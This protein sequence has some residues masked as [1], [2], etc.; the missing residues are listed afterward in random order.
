MSKPNKVGNPPRWATKFLH[1]YCKDDLVE[2]I[3]GDILEEYNIRLQDAS[4]VRADLFYCMSIF[5]FLR[6]FAIRQFGPSTQNY[7]MMQAN[8][9][10]VAFRNIRKDK[11]NSFISVFG[12][13]LAFTASMLIYRVVNHESNY[14]AF[15]SNSDQI[16]RVLID[17][18]RDNVWRSYS[19][20][21]PPLGPAIKSFYPEVA[22]S[23]RFRDNPTRILATENGEKVFYEEKI[24]Y[25]D[26]SIF[27][28]FT[29][30][31]QKG[32]PKTALQNTTGI[33]L[34]EQM[35]TKYFGKQDP[36]GK[37]LLL[38]NEIPF[39]V[40]GI[41]APIP[42]N[43]H[44]KFDFLLPFDAFKVP[45]GYTVTL[46]DFGWTSFHTYIKLE[47]NSDPDLLVSKLPTFAKTHFNEEQIA[48][49]KYG[50]IPLKDIY[51]SE[52]RDE[53][54]SSGNK[55]YV[56]ILSSIG[57]LLLILAAFNFTN[58]SVAR[59][60]SR[61]KET[62]MR[63]SLGSTK[64]GLIMRYLSEPMIIVISAVLIA[65][66]LTPML[67]VQLN[68]YFNLNVPWENKHWLEIGLLFTGLAIVIGILSG[69]Y[70]AFIMSS[71][72]PATIL[73]GAFQSSNH[74]G[75][76]QKTLVTFQYAI[77]SFLLI[78]SFIISAQINFLQSRDLGFEKD[79]LLLLRMPGEELNAKFSKLRDVF[80]HN[81]RVQNLSVGGGRMDGEN[82]DV[83][84]TA[85]GMAEPKNM[86]IDAV[87]ED[88]YLTIGT[89]MIAGREF[90][91]L[92]PSDSADGVII[93][94][95]AAKYFNWEPEEAL[96]KKV[97]IGGLA[98]G[99]VIGVVENFHNTSLHNSINPLVV[100]YP[101][102]LL[103]DIY[104]RVSPGDI[105]SLISGLQ[106]DWAKVA[107]DVPFDFV[108]M[109]EH[110][111]NLYNKDIQFSRMVNVF[112]LLTILISILGLYGL[113]ALI[114]T[115]RIKEISIRKILGAPFRQLIFTLSKSF[116]L[117]I[118]IANL[119]AW[120][121]AFWTANIWLNDFAYH[122]DIPI[123][124]F[125]LALLITLT[126]S[127]FTLFIQSRKVAILNPAVAL[128]QE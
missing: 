10:K 51:F 12:L 14:D 74:G 58:I 42:D 23:M 52:I 19:S 117:L 50:L 35:A 118:I 75:K 49:L 103:Q 99:H 81:S 20:V 78:G 11:V 6:P 106:N 59:S 67:L 65:L 116:L 80:S 97:T 48:R 27:N 73:R 4:K 86:P 61:A 45:P 22:E 84:V 87:R 71:F 7:T 119:I 91:F 56:I 70:P 53:S 104:L 111:Q 127:G 123:L 79:E 5:S 60:L 13:L 24:I 54:I 77:T 95:E 57:V 21:G 109:N 88:F 30:P 15:H 96:G 114:S 90:S 82:G 40:T 120:P 69:L 9:Y 39:N 124:V 62:G 76:L 115:Q 28:I 63:K 47:E 113:I 8:Y 105:P 98:E 112:A 31:L 16:F 121:L 107:P 29:Y 46:A 68:N 37:T 102:T 85:E 26:P 122:T 94:R 25:A 64:V 32:D 128:K 2:E 108:F 72:K 34:T 100:Y 33:V 43:S 126:V 44:F 66:V 92:H 125:V 1:W 3:E 101:R 36:M 93:N 18:K 55:S 89:P 41:L 83:P 110:L 38:D 17:V